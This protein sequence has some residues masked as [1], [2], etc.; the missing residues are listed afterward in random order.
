M[1]RIVLGLLAA[2]AMCL[3]AFAADIKP[4]L[5]YDLKC[6]GSQADVSRASE[7]S[8]REK[9]IRAGAPAHA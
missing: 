9:R 3:P 1:K 4:A 2:S 6:A 8:Q 5:L 7:V